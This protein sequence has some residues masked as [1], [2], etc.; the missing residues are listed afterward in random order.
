[1]AASTSA[2]IAKE[3][4]QA[5]HRALLIERAID[6]LLQ[7]PDARHGQVRIGR[8]QRPL[9]ERLE[10]CRRQIGHEQQPAHEVRR[11][12]EP[13]HQRVVVVDRLC[14]RHVEHRPRRLVERETGKLRV[15][16]DA[17]DSVGVDVLRQVEAE[18]LVE[19]ILAALEEALDE[20]FVDD[21]DRR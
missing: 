6:L 11:R 1:M 2:T 19:R 12:F 9:Q 15:A 21:R 14:E 16:H 20:C 10:R 4:G 13:L 8:S 3:S 5:R 18:V 17:D 7:R